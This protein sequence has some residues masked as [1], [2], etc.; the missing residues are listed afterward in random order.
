MADSE[1]QPPRGQRLNRLSLVAFVLSL[2]IFL[3]PLAAILG[4]VAMK[5][6]LQ[7]D[8]KGRGF[9]RFAIIWGWITTPL[10][11]WLVI[12]PYSLA[13]AVGYIFGLLSP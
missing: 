10:I 9:A 1:V 2:L 12:S 5:Q 11:V 3:A 8:D 7:K 4:H 13:Y 6:I